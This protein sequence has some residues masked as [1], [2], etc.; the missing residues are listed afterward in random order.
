[1]EAGQ[2][3]AVEAMGGDAMF[4]LSEQIGDWRHQM[5]QNDTCRPSDIDELESH[6]RDE[7]E[8]LRSKGLSDEEAFWVAQHRLGNADNLQSEFGKVNQRL[9]WQRRLLWLIG[10]YLLVSV[11]FTLK[12][13]AIAGLA[14]AGLLSGATDTT[15]VAIQSS[16]SA[17]LLFA[18]A[19]VVVKCSLGMQFADTVNRLLARLSLRGKLVLLVVGSLLITA[20]GTASKIV[21]AGAGD[22]ILFARLAYTLAYTNIGWRTLPYVLF[23]F[24]FIAVVK[25]T[26]ASVS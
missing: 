8:G 20:L 12:D 10:G 16:V 19:F 11:A 13:L 6:L 21:L 5:Q 1:M 7:I 26:R 14:I 22:P 23:I 24:L 4:E 3:D 2:L 18:V 17:V 15:L 25:K 9:T